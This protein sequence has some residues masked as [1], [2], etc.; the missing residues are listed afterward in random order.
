MDSGPNST[1]GSV[2]G[3]KSKEKTE[4]DDDTLTSA[5]I[6]ILMFFF[7]SVKSHKNT[8]THTGLCCGNSRRFSFCSEP[9]EVI[10][11]KCEQLTTSPNT[12]THFSGDRFDCFYFR[13]CIWKGHIHSLCFCKELTQSVLCSRNQLTVPMPSLKKKQI[14]T[15]MAASSDTWENQL[16][17]L[18]QKSHP[19]KSISAFTFSH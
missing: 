12:E 5:M 4:D 6:L 17:P 10:L 16:Q 15:N 2:H 14:K 11:E 13:P 3:E 1:P 7:N 9:S 8:H 19:I 18:H